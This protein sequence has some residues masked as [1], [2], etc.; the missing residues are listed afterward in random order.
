MKSGEVCTY[1]SS[2]SPPLSELSNVTK[3]SLADE[4]LDFLNIINL[5]FIYDFF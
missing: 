3:I 4:Y 1:L 5:R 2:N